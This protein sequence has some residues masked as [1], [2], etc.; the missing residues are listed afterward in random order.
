MTAQE[1]VELI[2]TG[3]AGG[4]TT[5]ELPGQTPSEAML[6]VVNSL[7]KSR[8]PKLQVALAIDNETGTTLVI[9]M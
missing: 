4:A 6:E 1:I 5:V 2:I 7:L 8:S 3:T 9:E